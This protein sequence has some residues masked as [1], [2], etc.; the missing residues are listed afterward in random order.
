MCRL[1]ELAVKSGKSNDQIVTDLTVF[2]QKL[3]GDLSAICLTNVA[4]LNQLLTALN[5]TDGD[6]AKACQITGK[7]EKQQLQLDDA[8]IIFELIEALQ[9]NNMVDCAWCKVVAT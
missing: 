9:F 2:C 8:A 5:T 6:A 3:P 7:C 4:N 1:A